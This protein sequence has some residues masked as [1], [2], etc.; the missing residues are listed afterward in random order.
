MAT[1]AD[2]TIGTN[3]AMPIAEADINQL[4]PAFFRS[5]IPLTE[6]QTIVSQIVVAAL[7]A[8]DASRANQVSME[9]WR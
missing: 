4:V 1:P 9:N 8:V 2:Y 5:D 6:V 3:A 7:N